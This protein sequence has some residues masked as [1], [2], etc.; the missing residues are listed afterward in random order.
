MFAAWVADQEQEST[1]RRT[2]EGLERARQQGKALGPPRKLR[3][4]QA[5]TVLKMREDGDSLRKIAD[6]FDCPAHTVRR[7]LLRESSS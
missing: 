2:T 7:T 5:K 1:K 6:E 3:P 4:H